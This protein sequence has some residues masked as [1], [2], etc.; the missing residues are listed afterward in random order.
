M[1]PWRRPTRVVRREKTEVLSPRL[2]SDVRACDVLVLHI[3]PPALHICCY[4]FHPLIA[5]AQAAL[6]TGS[7]SADKD[8]RTT[9]WSPGLKTRGIPRWSPATHQ[10]Q[11]SESTVQLPIT[12]QVKDWPQP[13]ALPSLVNKV[14]SNRAPVY[15][16][17]P[18]LL[19]Q[20]ASLSKACLAGRPLRAMQSKL[21][22]CGGTLTWLLGAG[23]VSVLQHACC[24]P[25]ANTHMVTVR[26]M[27]Q[28]PRLTWTM[29]S[30]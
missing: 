9:V 1:L 2:F 13:R 4:P 30:S 21:R 27:K 12:P 24:T 15:A 10:A 22:K 28:H 25:T 29:D 14:T 20:S 6:H 7:G 17:G 23:S 11:T 19:F 16:N 3:W 5:C 18:G 8:S 26:Q